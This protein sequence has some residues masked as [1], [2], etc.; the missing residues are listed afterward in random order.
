MAY[1]SQDDLLKMIPLVELAELS[2]ESGDEPEAAVV[3]EA[4]AKA[5]GEIDAYLAVR[6]VLPLAAT[7]PQVK[8]LAV[9]MALYHLYSRRSVAPP[10]RRQKYDAAVAFLK[11]VAAGQA[12]VEG[13]GSPSGDNRQ[14]GEFSG[15]SRVFGRDGLSEW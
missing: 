10:V 12:L 8:N 5:A 6:Y 9:D 15:A 1:C 7:P 4:I 11:E 2:A 3:A 13:V 14:V